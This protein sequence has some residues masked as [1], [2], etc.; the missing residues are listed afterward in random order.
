MTKM[1][2]MSWC[3]TYTN[4]SFPDELV[5]AG[6]YLDGVTQSLPLTFLWNYKNDT[7]PTFLEL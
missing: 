1:I 5:I 6:C 7:P 4:F 3:E 2:N